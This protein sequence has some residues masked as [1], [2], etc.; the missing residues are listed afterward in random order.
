MPRPPLIHNPELYGDL[1]LFMLNDLS[2][3]SSIT[4]R[5]HLRKS[6]FEAWSDPLLHQGHPEM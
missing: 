4:S 3:M 1:V 2:L 5:L 6:Y